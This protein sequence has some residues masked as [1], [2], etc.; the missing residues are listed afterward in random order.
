MKTTWFCALLLLTTAAAVPAQ[1]V[2]QRDPRVPT[3]R[4]GKLNLDA[5][6]PR[7]SDGKPD[8]SGVWMTDAVPI[9]EHIPTVEGNYFRGS[10]HFIDVTADMKPEQVQMEPWADALLKQR[11]QD[12]TLDPGAYCKPVGEPAQAEIPF[13][14]KIVQTPRVILALYE[15][16]SIH[17]QIF[18]RWPQGRP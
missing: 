1:W 16:N 4:D 9:P 17:R 10:R 11:L 2:K 8:L 6:M 3:L 12:P 14:Y 15:E 5:R 7:T 18:S 13:P